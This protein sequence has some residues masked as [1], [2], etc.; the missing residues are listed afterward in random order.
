ML[1]SL[2]RPSPPCLSMLPS[3]C[4]PR[5]MASS[6][7]PCPVSLCWSMLPSIAGQS[8]GEGFI[9]QP[10]WLLIACIFSPGLSEPVEKLWA[11]LLG[12][13]SDPRP[14]PTHP[15]GYLTSLE[16]NQWAELRE[17]LCS[18]DDSA[19]SLSVIDSAMFVLCLD[20]HEPTTIPD[21]TATML[22]N[23]GVNRCV[24][25]CVCVCLC[26]CVCVCVCVSM[27][28]CVCV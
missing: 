1:A 6:S 4:K 20:E 14:P 3:K 5:R 22:H 19:Q 21:F 2:P 27:C 25:V 17:E 9:A 11:Q 16:R 12:I 18:H 8:L 24:R 13:L 15:V 28:V 26:L 10:V 7:I 23:Y